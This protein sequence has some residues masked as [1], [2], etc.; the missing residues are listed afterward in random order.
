MDTTLLEDF[1]G[2]LAVE[3]GASTHTISAYRGDLTA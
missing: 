1:L 3:R 2:Y